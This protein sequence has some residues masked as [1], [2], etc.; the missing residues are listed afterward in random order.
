MKLIY[1]RENS[2]TNSNAGIDPTLMNEKQAKA[3]K[4]CPLTTID[5]GSKSFDDRTVLSEY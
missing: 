3:I 1:K 2:K 5:T 4:C